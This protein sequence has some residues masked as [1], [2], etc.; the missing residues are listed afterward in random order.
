MQLTEEIIEEINSC[1][2]PEPS[3][4]S[5]MGR[6]RF[7]PSEEQKSTVAM[8]A[9]YGIPQTE[10]AKHVRI[11][12]NT[13]RKRFR[14]ELRHAAYD[15]NNQVLGSLFKMATT[16]HNVAAAI[17]WAKVRCAYRPGGA[18]YDN[19]PGVTTPTQQK[20]QPPQFPEEATS[21]AEDLVVF[22]VYNNDGEPNADY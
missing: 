18:P 22:S 20:K 13:L 9:S 10:I 17:F 5:N 19:A 21:G 14:K 15:A 4:S 16:R 7:Q 1:D 3:P 2:N 8:M 12:P 11:A 6:R